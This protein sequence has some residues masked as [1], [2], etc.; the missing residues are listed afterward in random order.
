MNK[1]VISKLAQSG[2][3]Y[4]YLAFL[5]EL[6][7]VIYFRNDTGYIL[8]P[9]LM[10]AMG[11]FLSYYPLRC[12]ISNNLIEAD[13]AA[14]QIKL[15]G[16]KLFW[17]I[18]IGLALVY[19]IWSAFLFNQQPIDVQQS[20][21]L[22]FIK[23]VYLERLANGEPVYDLYTGFQYG[24]F[25][26]SYLPAHWMP[27]LLPYLIGIDLRWACVAI[28][29]AAT[30]IFT[31]Q[32]IRQNTTVGGLIAI[33]LPYLL[34]FSI[35][36]KQGKDAAHTIEIMVTGYYLILAVSLFSS[37]AF[38]RALGVCLPLLSRYAMLFWVPVYAVIRLIEHP[39]KALLMAA[40]GVLIMACIFVPFLIQTPDMFKDF[41][42]NYLNGVISEWR[43]QSWQKPG[44]KP[45]QLYQGMGF[46]CWYY[47]FGKGG[48]QD[49][50]VAIKNTLVWVSLVVLMLQLIQVYVKRKMGNHNLVALL[51]LKAAL[52]LFYPF[53]MIPYVY[54]NWVPLMVSVAI[55]SRITFTVKSSYNE[56]IHS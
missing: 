46:A 35:Y 48:L 22:P 25:R 33:A 17:G 40:F 47:E 13:A 24:T 43:G 55:L 54:L 23:S 37:N 56:N 5:A 30:L 4:L 1:T 51:T 28:F 38:A 52:T 26:P 50:I 53:V 44:D 14:K 15:P 39:R 9:L 19:I 10:V 2:V 27:Y 31:K 45:F 41:N 34:V 18:S 36:L 11:L 21:I 29:I 49:K 16:R 32:V 3:L 42:G 20:D 7:L 8:S 12:K 6:F